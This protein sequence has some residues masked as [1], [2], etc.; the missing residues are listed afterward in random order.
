[1]IN[2]TDQDRLNLTLYLLR[3]RFN[4]PIDLLKYWGVSGPCTEPHPAIEDVDES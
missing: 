1:M 3:E 2:S 4:T